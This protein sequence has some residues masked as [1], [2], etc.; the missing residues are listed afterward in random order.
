MPE[1][2]NHICLDATPGSEKIGICDQYG[3]HVILNA[4]KQRLE[5]FSKFSYSGIQL[6][7]T[8]KGSK[9]GVYVYSDAEYYLSTKSKYTKHIEGDSFTSVFGTYTTTVVGAYSTA[10]GGLYTSLAV[11]G[12]IDAVLGFKLES[13]VGVKLEANY[14]GKYQLVNGEWEN[15]STHAKVKGEVSATVEAP[16]IIL[17]GETALHAR[18]QCI[19]LNDGIMKI[20]K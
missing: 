9:Y 4:A 19:S 1:D 13:C 7:N 3:N 15:K 18:G 5:L 17:D 6:G 14:C 20:K 12:K 10:V 2:G 8:K 16:F 11:A